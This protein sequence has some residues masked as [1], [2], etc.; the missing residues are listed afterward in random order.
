MAFKD[1]S[2]LDRGAHLDLPIGGRTYRIAS[3]P[4]RVGLRVQAFMDTVISA[5]RAQEQGTKIVL[6]TQALDD[7]QE[8]DLYRD[9]L[10]HDTYQS[11]VDDGVP[12]AAMKH[13]ALTAMVWIV[14]DETSAKAVWEGKAPTEALRR[15]GAASTTPSRASMSGTSRPPARRRR[16]GGGRRGGR[17]LNTGA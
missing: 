13:A 16:R 1:W 5:A 14:M 15:S 3:P 4:A 17:S 10:G 11:M 9:V 6:D 12:F 2:E 8:L 7:A